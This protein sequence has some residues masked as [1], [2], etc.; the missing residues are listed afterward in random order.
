VRGARAAY[1]GWILDSTEAVWNGFEAH[2][3]ALWDASPTGDAYPRDLFA[4][5]SGEASLRAAQADYMR[6][7]FLQALGFAGTAM[8]RRTLGLAHNIDMEAIADPDRRA[9]CERR[10]LRLARELIVDS[11][12]F[13]DIAAVT[14]RAREIEGQRG[15]AGG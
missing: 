13:A 1:Q 2:F 9:T 8:I 3:L 6:R 11:A 10:N 12:R 14:R 15:D 7:L 5:A 4:G